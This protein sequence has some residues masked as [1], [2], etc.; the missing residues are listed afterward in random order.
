[1]KKTLLAFCV[2]ALLSGPSAALAASA[3][4]A[5]LAETFDSLRTDLWQPVLGH[6]MKQGS[7]KVENSELCLRSPWK[8]PCEVEVFSR[9]VLSGDFSVTATYR[10][11]TADPDCRTNAGLVLETADGGVSYKGYVGT[12]PGGG[13]FFRSRLD[14]NGVSAD[15][16]VKGTAAPAEGKIR[17]TRK[18]GRLS[19]STFGEGGWKTEHEF[20]GEC[21]RPLG[22]R[23]KLATGGAADDY[24]QACPASFCLKD[25]S[26]DYCE[27]ISD[28]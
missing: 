1:M 13:R 5:A 28:R 7:A 15:E 24:K 6:S 23:F 26:V 2:L 12:A 20:A 11:E 27:R 21:V 19:F 10:T 22:I 17:I 18:N 8:E 16:T 9:F 4:A 3:P 14:R 25:L